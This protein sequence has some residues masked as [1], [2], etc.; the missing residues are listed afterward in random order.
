[1]DP[2]TGVVENPTDRSLAADAASDDDYYTV[3][4]PY[5]YVY[6][7]T[8]IVYTLAFI[9][10]SWLAANMGSL[11]YVGTDGVLYSERYRSAYDLALRL[12][13]LR[14]WVPFAV[15]CML[16]YRRVQA[17][18]CSMFWIMVLALL[19]TMDV[20]ALA[21]L[22]SQ[23]GACNT[24][25]ARY[26]N[27]C[28]D[29]R[30]CAV[31]EVQNAPGNDCPTGVGAWAAPND[32]LALDDLR[33]NG[34]FV[35][36]FSTSIVFVAVELLLVALPLALWFRRHLGGGPGGAPG[37]SAFD[38]DDD[39]YDPS[40]APDRSSIT[41]RGAIGGSVRRLYHLNRK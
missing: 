41:V 9:A 38:G 28:N 35:W 11:H 18:C 16:L 1:M 21:M 22:G 24:P 36:L 29:R 2:D 8:V 12:M 15:L 31:A 23:L 20:V 26:G 32:A 25:Q 27:P 5:Y 40:L 39:K 13:G 3:H 34:D 30:W 10:S 7:V 37:S 14:F 4:S 6:N 17:A 33:K 19:F